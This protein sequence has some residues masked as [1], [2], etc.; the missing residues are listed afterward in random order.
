MTNLL[1]HIGYIF[2]VVGMILIARKHAIGWI[3]RMS[4]E[5]LWTIVGFALNMSSIWFWC[6]VF[7]CLDAYGYLSWKKSKKE[8]TSSPDVIS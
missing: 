7:F 4:G 2:L 8:L 5:V 6:L 1:G 3:F